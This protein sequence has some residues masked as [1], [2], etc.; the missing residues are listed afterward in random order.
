LQDIKCNLLVINLSFLGANNDPAWLV[1]SQLV[2]GPDQ[3]IELV[4]QSKDPGEWLQ[5]FEAR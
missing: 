5:S 2:D 4:S 3:G 1:D